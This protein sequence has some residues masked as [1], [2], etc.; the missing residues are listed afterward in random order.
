MSR[1]TITFDRLAFPNIGLF[2]AALTFSAHSGYKFKADRDYVYFEDFK[3]NIPEGL[4]ESEKEW[5]K[6]IKKLIVKNKKLTPE[7][8]RQM[9]QLNSATYLY[10]NSLNL[11]DD[12]REPVDRILFGKKVFTL[13]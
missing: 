3:V 8:W 4:E 2:S 6:R 10:K 9:G 11:P 12:L 5:H 1:K 7:D 13:S